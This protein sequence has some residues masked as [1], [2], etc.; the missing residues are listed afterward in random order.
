MAAVLLR[1]T[2][3]AA[4]A[5]AATASPAFGQT[6]VSFSPAVAPAA[7]EI[8]VTGDVTP[9]ALDEIINLTQTGSTYTFTRIGGP[10]T[11]G[12]AGCTANGPSQVIC[13]GAVP[14]ISIDLAAGNDTLSTTAVT[15]PLMIAGGPG[16]D[17]LNGG[18][19][20]DVL[21]GGDGNDALNGGPG[22]DDYFGEGGAD[23]IEAFDGNAER[24]AC[25]GGDDQAH[26]DFTDILAECERGKDGDG[27][28][29]SSA[30][31]CNDANPAIHP[32]AVDVPENGV[33]E[34]CS[35]SDALILDRDRDGFAIPVDCNDANPSVHPGALEVRGNRS[36]EN[37]DG[38]ADGFAL[39]RSL[40]STGWKFGA[41]FTALQA[42]VVRNAPAGA[43]IAAT[44]K[45]GG[46]P[47][48]G[49]KRVTVKRDLA[50]TSLLRFFHHAKLR[51]GAHLTVN[52]TAPG[53]VGRT[54]AYRIR[55]GDLPALKTTC[56][57]PGSKTSRSC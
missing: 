46:C 4:C 5:L 11:P 26:N 23:V 57:A 34:D 19:G 15:T 45:G 29:F 47:F 13:N 49:T 21:D 51:E 52:I 10:I 50:P 14:S 30:A 3:L 32:G 20:S 35:G 42:L 55:I 6:T 7:A 17:T 43:R 9:A 22:V 54:Y 16:N 56:R 31:D 25:G 33:D 27:D 40:V 1:L 41:R 36:D 2:L 18:A 39:L 53:F 37:C 48:K 8:V 28:G 44:C 12:T 24:I 38:R